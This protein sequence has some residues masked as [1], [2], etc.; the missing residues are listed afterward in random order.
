MSQAIGL[1]PYEAGVHA[2]QLLAGVL[3]RQLPGEHE[4]EEAYSLL[5]G[6]NPCGASPSSSH[7]LSSS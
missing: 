3:R 2:A 4:S 1:V 5:V 7:S 6:A